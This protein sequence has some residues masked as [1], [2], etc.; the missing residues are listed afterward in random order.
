MVPSAEE[1]KDLVALS[2][3][4]IGDAHMQERFLMEYFYSQENQSKIISSAMDH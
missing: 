1:T 4:G 2:A 3:R